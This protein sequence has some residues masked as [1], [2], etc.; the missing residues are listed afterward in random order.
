[1]R[2]M[3]N[4]LQQLSTFDD[5]IAFIS[6]RLANVGLSSILRVDLSR[7]DVGISVVRVI[8]PGLEAPDDDPSYRAGAR[9]RKVNERRQTELIS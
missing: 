3:K 8:V 2:E 5:D 7:P 4:D 9:A 6:N 1:M